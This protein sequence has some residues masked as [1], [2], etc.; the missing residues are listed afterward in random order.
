MVVE[1]GYQLELSCCVGVALVLILV[2]DY[3]QTFVVRL[4]E[5]F[6]GGLGYAEDGIVV[7]GD[8]LGTHFVTLVL[9]SQGVRAKNS[10]GRR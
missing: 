7:M 3:C 10:T 8:T 2:R 6:I 5:C 9:S 4:D 1:N